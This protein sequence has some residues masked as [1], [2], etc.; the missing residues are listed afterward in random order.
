MT[1]QSETV[2]AYNTACAQGFFQRHD[3]GDFHHTKKDVVTKLRSMGFTRS[4]SI[5]AFESYVKVSRNPILSDAKNRIKYLERELTKTKKQIS[6]KTK[7]VNRKK[8]KLDDTARTVRNLAYRK[9][10]EHRD[11]LSD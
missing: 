11:S 9:M 6:T 4:A 1:P 5:K 10:K 8:N 7:S 3:N 2:R